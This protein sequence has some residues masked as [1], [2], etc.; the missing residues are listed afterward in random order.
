MPR[1]P[2]SLALI[3]LAALAS[4]PAAHADGFIVIPMPPPPERSRP[5]PPGLVRG[6]PLAVENHDVKVTIDGQVAT[7]EVDQVFRNP[8]DQRLEGLYMFPLPPDAAL[9]QFSMWIDGKEMQGEVLDKDKALGIYEG[10]VRRL[11]DPALLEYAGRGMFKVRIF[12]IEP[13][14]TKRVRLTYRQTLQSD[15]GRV[16]YRYPLNTEKFSS[17]PLQRASIQVSIASDSPIKGIYS[18]WHRVDVR[19]TSEKAALASWEAKDARPSRDFVLDY[20][21]AQGEVGA[22]IRC[23][24]E[25]ARDGSFLLTI[26]PQV[27]V[28][29]RVEKD[30]VFVVDTSGTMATDDKMAQARKA[31]EYMIAKL[32]PGDRFG[33][34]DFATDA[35]TYKDELVSA[36]SE[37]KAG[38]THYVR[39]LKARGGTAID[40][41]LRRACAFRG[42]GAAT[43]PFTVVFMTDGEPT[44]GEREPDRILENLAKASVNKAARVFVWGVG[45]D[46]NANLLDRIAEQQRGDS[47][48]VLPGEDIEVAMSS[49]YDKISH[50]VLT[51]L[52]LKIEGVRTSE[53]YPRRLPDLFHGGQLL[54]LGRFSGEGHAAIRLKG[55]VG[56]ET[57]EYVFE[58]AF[59]RET[60]HVHVPR[61]WAKRK[62]GYLLEEIRKGGETSELKQEVV[63]LAR[64]HGL[65][66]P[67][68][69][70]LVLEE[71]ALG[72]SPTG[73]ARPMAEDAAESALRRLREGARQSA[74]ERDSDGFGAAPAPAS[75]ESG[76]AAVRGARLSG[77]FK[78]SERADLAESLD[79]EREVIEQAIRQVSG[80]TFYR[81]GEVWID[82][83]AGKRDASWVKVELMSDAYF[84]LVKDQP[85]LGAFLSLGKVVVCFGGKTY[86]I[87]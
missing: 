20:D 87:G 6:F 50:P 3:A 67:Y 61:L 31:L 82:S 48:Y 5:R 75:E 28:A 86:E 64:R 43:R 35:R 79:L 80:R 22:S 18:P 76:K 26:S 17:E 78:R 69:S 7:T 55:K 56:G 34:V 21:L 54:L 71:G 36:T 45:N 15:S 10:I 13:R 83:E 25:P 85:A 1:A 38:A 74:G 29:Q 59:K 37:E 73:G 66:T 2:I 58:A 63:R 8:T 40:E 51:D 42:E 14:G 30:V 77:R 24:A 32:E 16:R 41:A 81:Q 44:I 60:I 19:R 27:E 52:E 46:L 49:F 47:Y 53:I 65:P 62:I 57:K 72:P 84:Q 9:D 33:V 11:Q 70:Y 23:H 4:A 39:E 68:T 12:P